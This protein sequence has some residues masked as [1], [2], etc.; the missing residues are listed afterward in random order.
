MSSPPKC[1]HFAMREPCNSLARL[2][3]FGFGNSDYE[4]ALHCK[5]PQGVH[6]S[7]YRTGED[8]LPGQSRHP[9]HPNRSQL[10]L[11]SPVHGW[12]PSCLLQGLSSFRQNVPARIRD[13]SWVDSGRSDVLGVGR[14]SG[15]FSTVCIAAVPIPCQKSLRSEDG[16]TFPSRNFL[17]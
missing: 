4:A 9:R 8:P 16:F 17:K 10:R 15:T 14:G 5:E 2:H 11:R 12:R 6:P 13:E 3:A 7:K 1:R